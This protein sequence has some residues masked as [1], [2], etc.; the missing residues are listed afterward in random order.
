MMRP[1]AYLAEHH[2]SDRSPAGP[3]LA[4]TSASAAE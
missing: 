4:V 3:T 1:E 2:L